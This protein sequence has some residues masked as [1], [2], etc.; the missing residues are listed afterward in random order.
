MKAEKNSANTEERYKVK[1]RICSLDVGCLL[2][3]F[4]DG[5]GRSLC[6]LMGIIQ[7]NKG[8]FRDKI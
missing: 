7:A 1:R 4:L 3:P 2:L 6:I 5:G 8:R